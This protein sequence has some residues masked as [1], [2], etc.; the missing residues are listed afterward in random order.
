[1][2]TLTR[3]GGEFAVSDDLREML[4]FMDDGRLLISKAHYHHPHVRGFVARLRHMGRSFQILQADMRVIRDCYAGEVAQDESSN[5]Q[6]EAKGLLRMA[7]DL[8]ASDVHIRVS[9]KQATQIFF[10]IHSD[11]E[12]AKEHTYEYGQLLCSTMYQAMTDVSSATFETLTRQDARIS[13]RAH[14]PANIDGVRIAT[15]PQVDGFL[16]VL[17]LFY[18]DQQQDTDLS[19]LGYSPAQVDALE[20]IKGRPTGIVVIAGP[21]GSGKSTTLQRVLASIIEQSGGKKHVLTVEDPPEYPIL[22]AVQ[23]PITNAPTEEDRAAEYQ[24]AIKGAM[25]L[26]PDIIMLS[27]VRDPPTARLAVQAAMTGHQVWT[28]LHANGALAIAD[29]LLDLGVAPILLSDP[30]VV[31]GLICQRLIKTLCPHCKKPMSEHA[32]E[33]DHADVDRFARV[34]DF[35]DVYLLGPGCDHCRKTGTKGRTV[36]AEVV[37]TNEH[38]MALIRGNDRVAAL[39]YIHR[40]LG[41]TSMHEH[42]IAKVRAGLVDPFE[43]ESVVGLLAGGPAELMG[44]D[45]AD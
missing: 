36:I 23:T 45:H 33:L 32:H 40:E 13:S 28:T 30:S 15:T 14:L 5:M 22:G 9:K 41:I 25:R 38:L 34:L 44:H 42:A 11:L 39:R 43:A 35:R 29:R 18:N 3:K 20:Y 17:R 12:F 6:L 21:T 27:E 16:M 2:K 31:A 7:S 24:K 4:A 10:R 37:P 1:M 26:D 8:R 19:S